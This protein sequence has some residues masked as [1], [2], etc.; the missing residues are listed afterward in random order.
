MTQPTTHGLGRA[1]SPSDSR[2]YPM[3]NVLRS[4]STIVRGW[5]Y[6][7][8]L[9]E[10]DQNGHPF[11]VAYASTHLRSGS[12]VRVHDL[13][14]GDA[15]NLYWQC[16]EIDGY[17]GDGTWVRIA[18]KVMRDVG[19]IQTYHWAQS[20]VDVADW[21]LRIGPVVVGTVWTEAMFEPDADGFLRPE[22]DIVGGHAYLIDG[23]N[24]RLRR[25]RMLNSWGR[26]WG[27]ADCP[28]H[29]W[30]AEDDLDSLLFSLDGEAMAA[31]EV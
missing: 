19:Y 10:L 2:D 22:G 6:W 28:A 5:R 25:F 30:I 11:C 23:Y 17:P 20:I 9:A 4:A 26:S 21:V 24:A 27:R 12:P 31:T 1:P 3:Q 14:E 29:A 7:T 16:K 18:A 15:N 8:P 13:T